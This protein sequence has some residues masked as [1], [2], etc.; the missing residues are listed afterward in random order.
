MLIRRSR[1]E[2]RRGETLLENLF[3]SLNFSKFF[4]I[5]VSSLS[6]FSFPVRGLGI[7]EP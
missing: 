1:G 2:K 6:S 5:F 7:P 4:M 3:K